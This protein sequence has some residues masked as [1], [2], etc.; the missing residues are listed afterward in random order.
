VTSADALAQ[1]PEESQRALE[2]KHLEGWSVEAIDQ[3]RGRS[4]AGVAGLLRR[5]L[6]RLRQ[7]LVQQSP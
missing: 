4:D 2:L 3:H 6:Q 7:L 1:L 5:G